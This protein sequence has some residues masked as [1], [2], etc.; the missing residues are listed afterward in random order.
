MTTPI[1]FMGACT[2]TN[3][4]L[5][6]P[7]PSAFAVDKIATA[8]INDNDIVFAED[9]VNFYVFKAY[10][11]G[12]N[13]VENVPYVIK[14]NDEVGYK[15]WVLTNLY[16][17]G[18]CTASLSGINDVINVTDNMMVSATLSATT[19]T[20][21]SGIIGSLNATTGTV[22]TLNATSLSSPS[23]SATNTTSTNATIT[24][25][26]NTASGQTPVSANHLAI[27]SYVDTAVAN[28]V[29]SYGVPVG[30][31]MMYPGSV[32]PSGWLEEDGSTLLVASYPTLFAVL[33]YRFGGNGSTNFKLPNPRGKYISVWDHGAGID[34]DAANR[35]SPVGG[36]GSPSGDYVGYEQS[37]QN[38]AHYH[39]NG[40]GDIYTAGSDVFIYGH[41]STD[42]PGF[43]TGSFQSLT[44]DAN[45]QG[46]TSTQGGTNARPLNTSRMI[47]IKA[48]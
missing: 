47:I 14:P 10:T 29:A 3:G 5:T 36:S 46:Y 30:T 25:I 28:A 6:T 20:T 35:T 41:T 38:A 12:T 21:P 24:N 26:T 7:E 31:E 8:D 34:P 37:S 9:D 13:V 18:I 11:Y 4:S 15:R 45:T 33:G 27:K 44:S 16:A 19:F 2:L 39:L 1:K 43:S 40:C 23:I 42:V 48:T 32:P 17:N 22:T